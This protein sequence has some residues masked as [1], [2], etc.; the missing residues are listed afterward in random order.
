MS[1]KF[2]NITGGIVLSIIAIVLLN[3]YLTQERTQMRKQM[4]KEFSK[5]YRELSSVLVAKKDI[6]QG[7]VITSDLLETKIV[8]NQ[9][10]Q[11]NAVTSLDR[12]SGM[13]VAIPISKGEQITLN[14]LIKPFERGSL[15]GAT[16]VGKRAITI[17]VDNIAG[18][19]GMIRPGDYVDVIAYLPMRTQTPEGKEVTQIITLPLFQNVLVLA[20]RKKLVRGETKEKKKRIWALGEEKKEE[21]SGLSFSVTLAL[22]PQQANILSFVSEQGK[23]RL[24][25]RSPADATVIKP[26]TLVTWD[27][28][29]Q[30]VN[31]LLPKVEREAPPP[32]KQVEIYRGLKRE[33]IPLSE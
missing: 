28:V 15:A 29:F 6:P 11:P 18:L 17:T 13:R 20:M 2:I 30:Y 4:K 25:L 21:E 24:V 9:Y 1:R 8:P 10:I 5:L 19:G 12:V 33:Y 22:T 3:F 23:I 14:K 32:P 27:T 31:S 26:V 16:P 7:A